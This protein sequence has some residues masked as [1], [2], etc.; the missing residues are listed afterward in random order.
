[1]EIEVNGKIS[2]LDTLV[3]RKPYGK[4]VSSWYSKS[5]SSGRILNYNSLHPKSQILNTA[6]GFIYRVMKLTTDEHFDTKEL[7]FK[8]LSHNK[9]PKFLISKLITRFES[10]HLNSSITSN[11]SNLTLVPYKS[12]QYV[13]GLSERLASILNKNDINCKITFSVSHTLGQIFSKLKDSTSK[14]L[15]CNVIYKIP[16]L[17]CNLVYIGTTGQLLKNRLSGHKSDV[18]LPMRNPLATSL[19]KHAHDEGH[20]FGLNDVSILEIENKYFNRLFLEMVYINAFRDS[21]VNIKADT[22]DL[23]IVYSGFIDFIS[24][25]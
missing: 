15:R 9:Y 18:K 2:F 10:N 16:C 7:I 20:K 6:Y 8:Y 13:R 24:K 21:A 12:I 25:I 19:C 22:K 11:V 23:S 4:I 5:S 17:D 1:M 3:T 14:F